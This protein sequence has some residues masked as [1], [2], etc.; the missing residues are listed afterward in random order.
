M[1]PPEN[2]I[3]ARDIM[4]SIAIPPSMTHHAA[5]ENDEELT[6]SLTWSDPLTGVARKNLRAHT[7]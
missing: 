7:F 3:L 6:S 1:P 5:G 4:V 2:F